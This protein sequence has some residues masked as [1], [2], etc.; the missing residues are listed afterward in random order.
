MGDSN[1]ADR[2][3]NDVARMNQSIDDLRER[4]RVG[5]KMLCIQSVDRGHAMNDCMAQL[6]NER[7]A[8]T[9]NM[10]TGPLPACRGDVILLEKAVSYPLGNVRKLTHRQSHARICVSARRQCAEHVYRTSH[11]GLGSDMRDANPRFEVFQRQHPAS[12]SAGTDVG[13]AIV[14]R[15]IERRGGRCWAESEPGRGAVF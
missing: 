1:I 4:S 9:V 14:R 12:E 13:L 8:R 11:S 15:A 10:G 3:V 5:R 2:I 6:R 7:D